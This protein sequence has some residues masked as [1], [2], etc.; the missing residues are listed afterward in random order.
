MK[1]RK[2]AKMRNAHE[3]G[4]PT[5]EWSSAL[6]ELRKSRISNTVANARG[7]YTPAGAYENH[8]EEAPAYLQENGRHRRDEGLIR[9][10]EESLLDR[11]YIRSWIDGSEHSEQDLYTMVAWGFATICLTWVFLEIFF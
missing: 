8:G 6:S 1:H 9:Q 7:N 5:D 3:P 11:M 2:V 10:Y 4:G